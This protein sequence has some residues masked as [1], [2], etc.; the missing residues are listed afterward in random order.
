MFF[1]YYYDVSMMPLR[2]FL[3]FHHTYFML[4][5]RFIIII[6]NHADNISVYTYYHNLLFWIQFSFSFVVL[7]IELVHVHNFYPC[8]HTILIVCINT[9]T[10]L[11]LKHSSIIQCN[12]IRLT[13]PRVPVLLPGFLF[14]GIVVIKWYITCSA[15]WMQCR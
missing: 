4:P 7:I 14:L 15:R 9:L 1:S 6:D 11:N 13:C 12:S 8:L 3:Y 5:H 10:E 2:E